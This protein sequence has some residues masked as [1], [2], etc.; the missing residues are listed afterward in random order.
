MVGA[1]ATVKQRMGMKD[2]IKQVFEA[3][4]QNQSGITLMEALTAHFLSFSMLASVSRVLALI[5]TL[6]FT[7]SVCV[8]VCVNDTFCKPDW[9]A[10]L[11]QRLSR[12]L[13]VPAMHDV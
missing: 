6:I 4:V 3:S 5:F 13:A 11:L 8:S 12:L 7:L 10:T 1:D 2:K 9:T